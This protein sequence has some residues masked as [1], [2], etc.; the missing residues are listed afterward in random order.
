MG[1]VPHRIGS[2]CPGS[3]RV[4]KKPPCHPQLIAVE[5]RASRARLRGSLGWG[6]GREAELRP[7]ARLGP[8]TVVPWVD[9]GLR[10]SS[11][12]PAGP[13]LMP[14]G[15]ERGEHLCLSASQAGLRGLAGGDDMA[16]GDVFEGPGEPRGR[17]CSR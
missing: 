16:A 2:L 15:L 5:F 9:S 8:C 13:G 11:V 4:G 1:A 6:S 7:E 10:N 17:G 3:S 12:V 14:A